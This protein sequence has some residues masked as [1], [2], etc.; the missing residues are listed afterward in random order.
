[1]FLGIGFILPPARTVTIAALA[2]GVSLAVE[3]SQLYQADWINALRH[4]RVGGLILGYGFKW[5][6]LLCYTAGCLL[7][8]AGEYFAA[9]VRERMGK[10][11]A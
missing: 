7:G 10:T 5:S 4:T 2:L 1:M 6:D 3:V 11:K 9:R 8:T